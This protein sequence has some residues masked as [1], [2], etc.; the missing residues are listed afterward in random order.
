V[1]KKGTENLWS[2]IRF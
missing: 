2:V 1:I